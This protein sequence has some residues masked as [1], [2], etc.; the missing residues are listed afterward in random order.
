MVPCRLAAEKEAVRRE[1]EKEREE[2]VR[3]AVDAARTRW[4]THSLQVT[5]GAIATAYS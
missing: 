4:Q 1:V 3:A 2:A 5:T